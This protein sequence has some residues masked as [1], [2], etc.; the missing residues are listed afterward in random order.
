MPASALCPPYKACGIV[1]DMKRFDLGKLLAAIYLIM[2]VVIL[3]RWSTNISPVTKGDWFFLDGRNFIEIYLISLP[4]IPATVI[5]YF[6]PTAN[7]SS[8]YDFNIF[9]LTLVILDT[10]SWFYIGRWL[11]WTYVTLVSQ[12]Q[13][14]KAHQ[15][16]TKLQMTLLVLS[17]L[18]HLVIILP[19]FFQL[20][21]LFAY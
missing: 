9:T 10:I 12:F 1:E 4:L 16:L 21:L 11:Q 14:K 15:K 17:T 3:F 8:Y 2:A 6:T 5:S 13:K 7:I 19:L 20:L 18:L